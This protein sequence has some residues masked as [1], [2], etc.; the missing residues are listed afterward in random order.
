MFQGSVVIVNK[1]ERVWLE[2]AII[3]H[4]NKCAKNTVSATAQNVIKRQPII[5]FGIMN[6]GGPLT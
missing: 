3:H 2:T 4:F 1:L 6:N 5:I